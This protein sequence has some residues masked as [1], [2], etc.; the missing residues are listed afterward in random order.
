M[1]GIDESQYLAFNA[2]DMAAFD[3]LPT[4]A[5]MVIKNS[6]A[7]PPAQLVANWIHAYGISGALDML[8]QGCRDIH[9]EA[10]IKGLV[11]PVRPGDSLSL[12]LQMKQFV[13]ERA[14]NLIA[15]RS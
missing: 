8:Q 3:A 12:G 7:S 11:C 10:G 2:A 5:R 15:T 6:L 1:P 4:E 14:H 13:T 9:N